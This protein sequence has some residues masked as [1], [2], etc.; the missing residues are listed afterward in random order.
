[1]WIRFPY[2]VFL[3]TEFFLLLTHKIEML[4]KVITATSS[5]LSIV[6]QLIMTIFSA[7]PRYFLRPEGSSQD[8]NIFVF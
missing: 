6:G 8:I 5:F 3:I 1:M 4:F 7:L 2:L